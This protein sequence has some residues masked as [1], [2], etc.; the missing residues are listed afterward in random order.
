MKLLY[1]FIIFI[2]S[3]STISYGTENIEYEKAKSEFNKLRMN[4]ELE[5][6]IGGA[7][8]PLDYWKGEAGKSILKMGKRALPF[9]FAEISIGNFFF[10]VAAEKI[11]NVHPDDEFHAYDQKR[12]EFWVKWWEQHK[13]N[14]EW[15]LY[16][17][18]GP[19]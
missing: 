15:N 2:L 3:F 14:P 18:K 1:I 17:Q 5:I 12:S 13:N 8:N 6:P 16:I 9:I 7:H 10:N 19:N 4:W 11:T